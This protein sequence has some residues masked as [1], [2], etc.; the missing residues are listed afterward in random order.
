MSGFQQ[1]RVLNGQY[2]IANDTYEH[3]VEGFIL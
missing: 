2:L 1:R 3:I